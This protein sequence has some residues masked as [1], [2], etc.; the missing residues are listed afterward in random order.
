MIFVPKVGKMTFRYINKSVYYEL[1]GEG[2]PLILLHGFLES[3]I[4]WDRMAQELSK[5]F[6]LL[7]VDLP[8]HGKT[9]TF[10]ETHSMEFMAE[11]L[12]D[13]T[14]HLGWTQ[15][16]LMGHSMGGYVGL[17]F[18]EKY[19]EKLN[20]LYLLNSTAVADSPDRIINRNRALKVVAQVKLPFIAMAIRHLFSESS[21]QK[22][23]KEIDLLIA[24]AQEFSAEGIMANIRGM[25]DRKDRSE[26]L[27]AFPNAK[28]LLCG[29]EDPIIS[30]TESENLSKVTETPLKIMDGS[31][32][33]W[34]ENTPEIV[35]VVHFID[36]LGT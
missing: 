5:E 8:G 17:A 31:H 6:Q 13:L 23:A 10:S 28:Y 3:S 12:N 32:M 7:L 22:Y 18:A 30:L 15:F 21:L 4:I 16:S 9:D 2:R 33:G 11:L 26:V 35:K 25:R 34:L 27:K 36:F 19:T 20:S 14:D 29:T 1:K 24:H